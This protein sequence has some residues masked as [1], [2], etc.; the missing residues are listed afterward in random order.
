MGFLTGNN[1]FIK[2][3]KLASIGST[4]FDDDRGKWSV[5]MQCLYMIYN[6]IFYNNDNSVSRGTWRWKIIQKEIL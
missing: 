1:K 5:A 3:G 6:P 2:K 4:I